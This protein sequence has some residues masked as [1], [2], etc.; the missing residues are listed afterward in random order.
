MEHQLDLVYGV[1]IPYI[2]FF[3]FVAALVFLFRKPLM[4]MAEARRE[5]HLAASKEAASALE[6]ARAEFTAIKSKFDVL[7]AELS[8]FKAQSESVAKAEAQRLVAEGEKLSQQILAETKKL[9][10]EEISRARRE[11]R[12]EIVAAARRDAEE[13]IA[14]NLGETDKSKILASRISELGSYQI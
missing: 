10:G 5:K 9:A 12:D 14:K 2:N 7:D 13:K 4:A 3:I 1:I 6:R 11:L 8:S